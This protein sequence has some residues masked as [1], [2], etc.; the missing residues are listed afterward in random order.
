METLAA[1]LGVGASQ[2]GYIADEPSLRQPAG[3]RSEI[4]TAPSGERRKN[5]RRVSFASVRHVRTPITWRVPFGQCL[6]EGAGWGASAFSEA[7]AATEKPLPQRKFRHRCGTAVALL[8]RCSGAARAPIWRPSASNLVVISEPRGAFPLQVM[9]GA[10]AQVWSHCGGGCDAFS[11]AELQQAGP[12][13]D[14]A[15]PGN[16]A[17][18]FSEPQTSRGDV[19]ARALPVVARDRD[20]GAGEYHG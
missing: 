14:T 7:S 5:R 12:P 2:G 3:S 18:L 9:A 16:C 20:G 1:V 19:R 13:C 11:D 17:R 15:A 6:A 8:W 4:R 10:V